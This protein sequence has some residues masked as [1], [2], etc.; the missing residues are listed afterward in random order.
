MS[1]ESLGNDFYRTAHTLSMNSNEIKD[2]NEFYRWAQEESA[3]PS[4]VL[5]NVTIGFL[6]LDFPC[7]VCHSEHGEESGFLHFGRNDPCDSIVRF[8]LSFLT[9]YFLDF[10]YYL[11]LPFLPITYYL[12]PISLYTVNAKRRNADW[13]GI[14]FITTLFK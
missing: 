7:L 5:K 13:I 3:W 11:I 1:I 4:N 8:K 2:F 14:N 9:S 6:K 10:R 12:L